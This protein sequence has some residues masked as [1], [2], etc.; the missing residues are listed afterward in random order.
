MK[1]EMNNKTVEVQ[2]YSGQELKSSADLK[3]NACCTPRASK[4]ILISSAILKLT[5]AFSQAVV[6]QIP[7]PVCIPRQ[8][9]LLPVAR[10]AVKLDKS[11]NPNVFSGSRCRLGLNL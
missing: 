2:A 7:L 9:R 1:N 8:D 11:I 4:S 3:T 5:T 10:L 6:H